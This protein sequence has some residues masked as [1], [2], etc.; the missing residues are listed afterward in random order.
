[1][2]R[3]EEHIIEIALCLLS[4]YL[5]LNELRIM[6]DAYGHENGEKGGK[7]RVELALQV[8]SQLYHQTE[9]EERHCTYSEDSDSQLTPRV[10][11][12]PECCQS[13]GGAVELSSVGPEGEAMVPKNLCIYIYGQYYLTGPNA[14]FVYI[15]YSP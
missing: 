3:E 5:Y 8:S 14:L 4:Q 6:T 12:K 7:V 1:M 9:G 10:V 2:W 11:H 15:H 13:G